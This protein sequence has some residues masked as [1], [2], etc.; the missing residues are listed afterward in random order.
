MLAPADGPTHAYIG[1]SPGC[2]AA[3]SELLL[4]DLGPEVTGDLL[5]DTYAAQH[6]G[7]PERRAVQS[8]AVHLVLLCATLERGWPSW[9]AAWLRRRAVERLTGRM[10]WLD[11]PQPL[12][13]VDVTVPASASTAEERGALARG[14]ADDVWSAYQPHH[15]QVR[16]WLDLALA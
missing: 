7:V 13:R 9:R 5:T 14:W 2:W 1:A 12:G 10:V 6:P 15:A 16:G 3:F 4:T 11:A 8:L